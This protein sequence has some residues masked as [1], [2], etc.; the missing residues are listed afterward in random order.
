MA[1]D[2]RRD[3]L[4]AFGRAQSSLREAA[5][6]APKVTK[7]NLCIPFQSSAP[8]SGVAP[9]AS[10]C[11]SP[12]SLSQASGARARTRAIFIWQSFKRTA[13]AVGVTA[14]AVG[15]RGSPT[16]RT[17]GVLIALPVR[18]RGDSIFS[19]KKLS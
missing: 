12:I 11:I 1:L 6:P 16:V 7:G 15:F 9:P 19:G 4:T 8:K 10:E 14:Q 5:D 2:V 18:L 13:G 3:P 17:V